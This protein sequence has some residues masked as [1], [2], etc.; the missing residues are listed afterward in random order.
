MRNEAGNGRAR[1]GASAGKPGR[2]GL[3]GSAGEPAGKKRGASAG[4]R[5]S[6][7]FA[8]PAEGRLLDGDVRV[9]VSN[10]ACQARRGARRT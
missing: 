7:K 3:A 8:R 10:G 5:S 4:F 9:S 6:L 1:S 2:G